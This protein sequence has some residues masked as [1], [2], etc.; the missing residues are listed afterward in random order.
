MFILW[1]DDAKFFWQ[2]KWF[3]VVLIKQKTNK[4]I[5]KATEMLLGAVLHES[6]FELTLFIFKRK[7]TSNS[8]DKSQINLQSWNSEYSTGVMTDYSFVVQK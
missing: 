8:T 3:V 1:A 2:P 7:N 4:Q 6:L 5:T